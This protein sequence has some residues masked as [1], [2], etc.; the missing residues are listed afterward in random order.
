MHAQ[1]RTHSHA[2]D[3]AHGGQGEEEPPPKHMRM[4][5]AG[6]HTRVIQQQ[7]LARTARTRHTPRP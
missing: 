2:H 7:P 4:R 1:T 5:P 6:M 3:W